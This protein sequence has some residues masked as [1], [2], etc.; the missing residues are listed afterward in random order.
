[1]PLY[2]KTNGMENGKWVR[3][4]FLW[5]D[6]TDH[7]TDGTCWCSGVREGQLCSCGGQQH[8][9]PVYGGYYYQCEECGTIA[10]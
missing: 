2:R 4:N 10:I 7:P 9:Q 5:M 6:G 8:Y 1:M 3:P